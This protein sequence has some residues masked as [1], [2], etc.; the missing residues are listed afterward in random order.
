MR[1]KTWKRV[2]SM[3]F[4]GI[5][6]VGSLVGCSETEKKVIE[7]M[8][9][10][11]SHAVSMD[12]IGG[13][14]VMP[15]SG[16]YGPYANVVSLDGVTL[17]NL[18]SEEFFEA[19]SD[20][21]IN[22]ISSTITDYA[23]APQIVERILEYGEKH[24][25]GIVVRDNTVIELAQEEE[26]SLEDITVQMSK[27]MNSPAFA[28]MYICDEPYTDTYYKVDVPSRDIHRYENIAPILNQQFDF[29]NYQNALGGSEL[30]TV[31][32]DYK[33]YLYE[34][35]ETL[36]PDY[37]SFDFYPF[38][39]GDRTEE[40][41]PHTMYFNNLSVARLV[42]QDNDIPFWVFIQAGGNFSDAGQAFDTEEYYPNEWQ[43]DWN[44]NTCLAFG[45]QGINYFSLMQPYH[46]SYA[47]SEP[48]DFERNG[49]I[50]VAGNKNRWYYYAQNISSHISAI[51]SVL[52]NSVSKGVLA[53][54][55]DAIEDTSYAHYTMLEGESWRELK[56]IDG[57]AIVGCFNY[58]GKTAL[59][60]V[61]Y[62]YEYAQFIDLVFEDEYSVTMI[63]GG[64]T[65]KIKGD[66]V[67]LDMAA[68]E[69]VL[70]V[71]E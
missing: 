53:S 23:T 21:G 68:G 50:G 28:G 24:G 38:I 69:G 7:P 67:T 34:Y 20:A 10:E 37:L 43:F 11:E 45:A 41:L 52:M 31:H 33:A 13:K 1:R 5:I 49:L 8:E 14:D 71:F 27:Y 66:G 22:L 26:M 35:C 40:E 46:F 55:K 16:Y 3:F 6:A 60:V 70:L 63:Q 47:A 58:Q 44:I 64:E 62:S 18:V 12:F 54:G 39:Y 19:L 56:S 51:D 29:L 59:Y 17:P 61:N 65:S 48:Y 25:I 2:L 30:K 9:A 4:V 36:Q 15:I 57:D 32:G 42:A